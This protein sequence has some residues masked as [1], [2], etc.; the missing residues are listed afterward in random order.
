M[1]PDHPTP[2]GPDV[3]SGATADAGAPASGGPR[4]RPPGPLLAEATIVVVIVALIAGYVWVLPAINGGAPAASPTA[5]AP[6]LAIESPGGSSAPSASPEP[7]PEPSA[8]AAATPGPTSTTL[9][10]GPIAHAGG[11]VVLENDGSLA[12]IDAATAH[13]TVLAT[14]ADGQFL[15]PAWSPDGSRI[16]AI[17]VGASE[18]EIE[19]FDAARAE[20]GEPAAPIVVLRSSDIG[21]FYLSW[22]PDGTRI[23]YLANES[24]GLSLRIVPAD[25]S[26]PVDG[27]APNAR[28]KT[29]N[30]LYYDWVAKDRLLAHIGTGA[31]AFLG[32]L[33]IDGSEAAPAIQGPGDFRSATVSHDGKLFGYIRAGSTDQSSVVL[34]AR[35]GSSERTMPVF[36]SAAVT[37]APVGDLVASIGPTEPQPVAYT[38]PF[39]PLRVL[40]A[41]GKVRK[42]LDGQVVGFWWSP[43]GRT[44]AALRVQTIAGGASPGPSGSAGAAPTASA[45]AAASLDAS[46]APSDAGGAQPSPSEPPTEVRML[47]VDVASGKVAA[48]SVVVPGTLFINQFLTYFDQYSVSHQLWAPDSS[49]IL[50]PIEDAGAT[51]I[52]VLPRTGNKARTFEGA[53]AFWSP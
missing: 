17:R 15:F 28:I 31:D 3:P 45:L 1:D 38:F 11:V 36:G 51:S 2:P 23:S 37:F 48:Q 52:E 16:A 5:S 13:E 22:S 41:A 47:F 49:S 7:S 50:L 21:P 4:R 39:G 14:A 10:G 33:A 29:G 27:S 9:P 35:D 20:T 40:D 34:A 6:L 8:S 43:D 46:A 30:P 42:L 12:V 25:G 32:E 44:I 24:T 18:N 26:A 53:M 19:V